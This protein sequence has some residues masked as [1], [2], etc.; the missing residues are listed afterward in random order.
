MWDFGWQSYRWNMFFLFLKGENDLWR[1]E[2][3]NER[4]DSVLCCA[5]SPMFVE[6]FWLKVTNIHSPQR[7]VDSFMK[8]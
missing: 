1:N 2:R 8:F 5:G 4:R 7:K 3:T 6:D